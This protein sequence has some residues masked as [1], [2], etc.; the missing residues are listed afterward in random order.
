MLIGWKKGKSFYFS[1]HLAKNLDNYVNGVMNRNTSAVWIIDGRSGLGKTTVSSQIGCYVSRKVAEWKNK[2]RPLENGEKH[3]PKFTLNS[4]CWTPDKF[5]EILKEAE[6]GDIIIMDESMILSNRSAMSQYNRAVIIMMSMIRSKKLFIIFNINSV[7]DLDKNLALHRADM[8][9]HLYA[10]NDRFAARGRYFV[11]PSAKGR[12]KNLYIIGKKYYSYNKAQSAFND[13]FTSYFPF[14][15]N[16]YERRKQKAIEG[17]FIDNKS[18]TTKVKDSRDSY[19]KYLKKIVKL[20]NT[21]IAKIG[22]LSTKTIGRVLNK[23]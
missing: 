19:I 16:E 1:S 5:I 14:D 13:K 22:D 11:V 18:E 21:K 9:I 20:K 8:L 3:K 4:Y 17:Y 7:F 12:L 2:K 15:N 10:V 23:E 6:E